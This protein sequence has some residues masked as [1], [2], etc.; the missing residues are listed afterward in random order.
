MLP[1]LYVIN[2]FGVQSHQ[3]S[4]VIKQYENMA[5]IPEYLIDV[6]ILLIH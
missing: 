6:S 3:F 4:T 2:R 1:Y 5:S